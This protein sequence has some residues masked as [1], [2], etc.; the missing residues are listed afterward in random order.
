MIGWKQLYDLVKIIELYRC[1]LWCASPFAVY[2][3]TKAQL[4]DV[5]IDEYDADGSRPL[6]SRLSRRHN[7]AD[8]IFN[9]VYCFNDSSRK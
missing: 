4:H 7:G 8:T 5:A 3:K 6:F 2:A 9:T 1:S